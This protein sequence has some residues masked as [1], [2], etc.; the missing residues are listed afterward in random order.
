[1]MAPLMSAPASVEVHGL[2]HDYGEYRALRGVD[3]SVGQGESV[4]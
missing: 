2:V 3:F 4:V 1:M